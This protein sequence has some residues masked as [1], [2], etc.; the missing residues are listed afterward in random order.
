MFIVFCSL[1]TKTDLRY[2]YGSVW[3]TLWNTCKDITLKSAISFMHINGNY[4]LNAIDKLGKNDSVTPLK[5]KI[6]QLFLSWDVTKTFL[7]FYSNINLISI[8][9]TLNNSFATDKVYLSKVFLQNCKYWLI[10]FDWLIF[11][12]QILQSLFMVIYRLCINCSQQDHTES[13]RITRSKC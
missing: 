13:R 8:W 7:V 11:S 6:G 9:F 2:Q 3:E 12:L 1:T 10:K 5:Q 4:D